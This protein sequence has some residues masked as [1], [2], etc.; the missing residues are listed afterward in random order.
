MRGILSEN[1]IIAKIEQKCDIKRDPTFDHVY[2]LDFIVD[3]FKS[4]AKLIPI[5]VQVTT[6]INDSVKL[7]G[8]LNERQKKTLL[9]KS[10]YV[11]VHPD[12]D[13]DS[14]G[15][16][17]IYNALV[18]FAFQRGGISSEIRGVRI[19]PDVS[20]EFFEIEEVLKSAQTVPEGDT[21][22]GEIV[23]YFEKR[24][25]GI[26][27]TA[28]GEWFLHINNITDDR[29]KNNFMPNIQVDAD[30]NV[31]RPIYV[32]F[33]NGGF[34]R[35]NAKLPMALNIRLSRQKNQ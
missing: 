16:E 19:N 5:G 21:V 18:A 24:G 35:Q 17:L 20:Y 30:C 22:T 31:T 13:I 29:L 7:R 12:V 4:I 25:F 3:R 27:K 15:S 28:D 34:Q 2:K 23:K 1:L 14:W 26:I 11:E 9:D 32:D 8:F 33:E 6:K 10:I